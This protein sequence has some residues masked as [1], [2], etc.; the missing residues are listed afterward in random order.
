M[1]H[2]LELERLHICRCRLRRWRLC[3]C[4]RLGVGRHRFTSAGRLAQPVLE[5]AERNTGGVREALHRKG[6]VVDAKSKDEAPEARGIALSLGAPVDAA[7]V[8]HH[9]REHRARHFPGA[10][11]RH[12]RLLL[13]LRRPPRRSRQRRQR[14]PEPAGQLV[15][16]ALRCARGR[17]DRV[18]L[19]PHQAVLLGDAAADKQR[20]GEAGRTKQSGGSHGGLRR[21]CLRCCAF[22]YLGSSDYYGAEAPS[23]FCPSSHTSGTPPRLVTL[24]SS[25]QRSRRSSRSVASRPAPASM[26]ASTS[27]TRP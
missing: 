3:C 24:N 18:D 13:L 25:R 27:S 20:G 7:G 19:G 5:R 23:S 15:G 9:V 2:G 1:D 22:V 26:R 6:S 8:L 16:L 14:R 11:Q 4:H 12:R 10:I 17:Q 21:I